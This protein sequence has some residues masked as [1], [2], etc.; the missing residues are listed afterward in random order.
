MPV[1]IPTK[2]GAKS[3]SLPGIPT[4]T[5][6]TGCAAGHVTVA[7]NAAINTRQTARVN[8]GSSYRDWL[9]NLSIACEAVDSPSSET[10]CRAKESAE[11]SH[12]RKLERRRRRYQADAPAGFAGRVHQTASRWHRRDPPYR[13]HKL[14][15]RAGISR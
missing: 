13:R 15:N 4:R 3:T 10:L 1:L 14:G 6:S 7:V 2:N 5:A 12:V 9:G 11:V 8:I